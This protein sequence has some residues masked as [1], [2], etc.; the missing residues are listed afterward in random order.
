[1][2][3]Y[4]GVLLISCVGLCFASH[5]ILL[6]K[7]VAGLGDST[8]GIVE[9]VTDC[10]ST[11]E[12]VSLSVSDCTLA[13]C[14]LVPGTNY[15]LS[16]RFI[17]SESSSTL[18]FKISV[19][20][21]GQETVIV[22]TPISGSI[23]AGGDY[24]LPYTLPITNTYFGKFINVKL[25]I[26]DTSTDRKEIC[27]SAGANVVDAKIT[28]KV[29]FD[30]TIGGNDV[31]R[32]VI[33]LFGDVVPRTVLNFATICT[34]GIDGK[35]YASSIFHR[36]I[37]RFMIQG[38]DIVNG[39]GTGSTSIYGPRFDDENFDIKHSGPGYLSMANAGPNTNG[40]Q[41]F[42][43]T[44]P[45]SWL[46]GAHV[47]FGKVLEGYQFVSV[48]ETSPTDNQ[49]RPISRTEIKACGSLPV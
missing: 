35:S 10:G 3:K 25:E 23:E 43:T 42:I 31:G 6:E 44:V 32:V 22:D 11:G 38:G 13:P 18:S 49:D 41:F 48:V 27:A 37:N 17:A 21:D 45:T 4:L 33:G 26:I 30:I 39:D 14:S 5:P 8:K 47:V 12:I 1:M 29:Y 20:A 19:T 15:A 7:Y 40:C 2:L 28:E 9:G 46:D 24:Q 16:L 36:V 34:E